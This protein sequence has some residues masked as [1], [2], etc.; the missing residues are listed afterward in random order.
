MKFVNVLSWSLLAIPT[1]IASNSAEKE[2]IVYLLNYPHDKKVNLSKKESLIYIN[3]FLNVDQSFTKLEDNNDLIDLISDV[4]LGFAVSKPDKLVIAIEGDDL[5]LGNPTFKSKHLPFKK[6]TK[7]IKHLEGQ[8]FK[9]TPEM[10]YVTDNDNE[11]KSIVQYFQYFDHRLDSIWKNF[12]EHHKQEI[13]GYSPT[14]DKNFINELSQ[15][16]HLFNRETQYEECFRVAEG[17]GLAEANA[18]SK[19]SGSSEVF[20][21]ELSSLLSIKRKIGHD[22][23]TYIHSKQALSSLIEKLGEKYQVLVITYPNSKELPHLNKRAIELSSKSFQYGNEVACEV[24]TNNCNSHGKCRKNGEY[25]SCLCEPSFNKTTS[26]TTTW[27]GYDCSKK[28]VS[29]EANLFLWTTIALVVLLVG[30]IKL[31]FSIGDQPLPGVLDAATVP[32]KGGL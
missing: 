30:G 21:V 3:S 8:K 7:T 25:W 1:V 29:V 22:A 20:F 5:E 31:M 10:T 9:L 24:A 19:C 6:V 28:D 15:L 12:T 27:V 14:N 4:Y 26:K 13:Q 32:K 17:D 2:A 11:D 16:I 18:D 23:Q